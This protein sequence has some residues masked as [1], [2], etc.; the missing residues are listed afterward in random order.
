[1]WHIDAG[2]DG[3]DITGFEKLRVALDHPC[4]LVAIHAHSMAEPMGEV[5]AV[6]SVR[7]HRTSRPIDLLCGDARSHARHRRILRRVNDIVDLPKPRG[8]C[9]AEPARA[10]DVGG[11]ALEFT[12][13]I[14]E[15]DRLRS[16]LRAGRSAMRKR[17]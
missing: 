11:V 8:W 9:I 1:A 17:G 16:E 6:P 7:D 14:D 15:H 4:W 13:G 3:E 12:A 10:C 5:L 2:F